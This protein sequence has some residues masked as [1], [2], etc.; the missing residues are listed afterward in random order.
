MPAEWERHDAIWLSWPYDRDSFPKIG[1]VERSY[2]EILKAIHESELINLLIRDEP[3]RAKVVGLLKENEIPFSRVRLHLM[4]YADVW[5]RDFGPTFVVN[6]EKGRLGMVNWVFNAWGEKYRELIR[7]SGIPSLINQDLKLPVFKPGIVLEGG[8][9]DVNGKGTLLTTEQCLLNRNRNPCLGMEEIE[10]YLKGYLGVRK[11]IW[12]KNG[13]AGDDTDGHI[14]DIA[15]FTGSSTVVCAYEEDEEDEN[16]QVLKDNYE[17]LLSASDQDGRDLTVIKLPMP[18]FVGDGKRLPAS[19]TNFYIGNRA[20]LVPIFSHENDEK[21]LRILQKVF[22]ERE[23]IGINCRAMVQG[24]GA[25]H[26][27]SQQQPA[28]NP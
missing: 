12:L 20:V 5:F 9:I 28:L 15:R 3:M 13:I 7:D 14:D 1:E 23:V 18:G 25:I 2:I 22:P 24:L 10:R 11:V 21:A 4:D 17:A 8:S 16:H 6:R 19:Y 27:I 26:C